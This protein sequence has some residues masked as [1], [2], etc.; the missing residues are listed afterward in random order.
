MSM[1]TCCKKAY[2]ALLERTHA[3]QSFSS[4]Y[5]RELVMANECEHIKVKD[6]AKHGGSWV[7]YDLTGEGNHQHIVGWNGSEFY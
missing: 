3:A 2:A 1:Q 4:D 7:A 5:A 6:D